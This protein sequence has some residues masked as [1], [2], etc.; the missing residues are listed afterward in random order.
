MDLYHLKTIFNTIVNQCWRI[1][2]MIS[3]ILNEDL[4]VLHSNIIFLLQWGAVH[5]VHQIS[6]ECF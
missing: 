2:Q 5:G 6:G 1:H 3:E 4:A